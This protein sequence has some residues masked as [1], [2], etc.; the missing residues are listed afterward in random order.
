MSMASMQGELY[1]MTFIDEFSR[2]TLIFFMKTKDEVLVRF[3]EFKA[4]VEN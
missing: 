2:K 4:Q 1:Y 3:W